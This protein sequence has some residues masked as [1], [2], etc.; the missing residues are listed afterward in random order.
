[1]PKLIV[2]L[3]EGESTTVELAEDSASIGRLPQ[4]TI[5]LDDVA[6]SRRHCQILRIKSGFELTDMKSRNGTKVNGVP[7]SRHVLADGDIIEIGAV[8]ITFR[9]Q[10]GAEEEEVVL[11]DY[12]AESEI[13]TE[14][15]C[16]LVWTGGENKGKKVPLSSDRT[17][18]G[19]K[20]SN[21]VVLQDQMV[22][23]YHCEV[24]REAGGY[25]LRDLG[26]TN[27]CVVNGEHVSESSLSHGGKLRLGKTVFVFVDPAVADF[28]QAM[29]GEEEAESDWGMMRAQVD[30]ARVK[31]KR[32]WNLIVSLVAV[33]FFG[34]IIGFVTWKPEAVQEMIGVEDV[35]VLA[36]VPGNLL[37]DPS[38]EGEEA[39]SWSAREGAED[40]V[41]VK[42]GPSRQGLQSL[43]VVGPSEGW[44]MTVGRC[45]EVTSIATEQAYR[46]SAFVLLDTPETKARIGI[47]WLSVTSGEKARSKGFSFSGFASDGG[48]S[49]V[50]S[51]VQAPT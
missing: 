18:F 40:L 46:I 32:T 30:M 1:M 3:P 5:Q 28:E 7:R 25:V 19:R 23:S 50:S 39:V 48:Y 21:T 4:N 24:T 20:E 8:R 38:F 36:T 51:V 10:S 37:P 34:A 11:E 41:G 29:A 22:S 2:M 12:G 27:G 17:T 16:Y 31:R 47:E 15:D 6:C 45:G 26:S 9:E 42:R 14:G 44:G 43:V 33:V 49:E 35:P 13:A